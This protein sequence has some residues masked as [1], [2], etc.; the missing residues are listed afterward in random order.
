MGG[1]GRQ[2]SHTPPNERSTTARTCMRTH[3]PPPRHTHA[4]TCRHLPPQPRSELQKVI[5]RRLPCTR[6]CSHHNPYKLRGEP[7][8]AKLLCISQTFNLTTPLT[9]HLQ[10]VRSQTFC[11][12]CHDKGRRLWALA[13]P[14]V[15]VSCDTLSD[16]PCRHRQHHVQCPGKTEM[17]LSKGVS[18]TQSRRHARTN[19]CRDNAKALEDW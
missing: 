3:A 7:F 12:H 4:H 2:R 13:L 5:I 18:E 11:R 10:S 8:F 9:T 1:A 17:P 14:R 15:D 16:L 6:M 19:G